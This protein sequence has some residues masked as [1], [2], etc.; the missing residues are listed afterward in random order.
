M[1]EKNCGN[2]RSACFADSTNDVCCIDT[3]KIFDS[4]RDQLCLEDMKILM[5]DN[6]QETLSASNDVRVKAVK[7]IWVKINTSEMPFNRGYYQV[8]I[9]YYFYV[10]LEGCI[11]GSPREIPGVA[12]YDQTSVLCGG[13]SNVSTFKSDV[14]SSFCNSPLIAPS[15]SIYHQPQIVV[16]VVEPIVLNLKVVD[17]CPAKIGCSC[18]L[19]DMPEQV[20]CCFDGNI[21]DRSDVKTA[22]ISLGVFALVRLQRAAQIIVPAGDFYIPEK[23]C[24]C[25]TN[26]DDA[27]S[28]FKAM[29]FPMEEF[30]PQEG[31]CTTNVCGCTTTA[32]TVDPKDYK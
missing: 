8:K 4:C 32:R 25:N 29:S 15:N 10:L 27:C 7:V 31:C 30:F 19:D 21:V 3:Y 14:N 13:E 17:K 20:C 5:T 2:P 16:D 28:L 6:A 24:S 1:N 23:D 11:N 26:F 9:R 22:F 18:S 12:I